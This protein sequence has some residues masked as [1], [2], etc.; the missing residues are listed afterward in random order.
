MCRTATVQF[1]EMLYGILARLVRGA[2]IYLK[3]GSLMTQLSVGG[4]SHP[5]GW[6]MD[7]TLGLTPHT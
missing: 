5:A 4:I 2:T 1:V 3:I 6:L 7:L